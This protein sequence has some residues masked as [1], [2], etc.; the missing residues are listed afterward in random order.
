MSSKWILGARPKTLPAAVVPVSLGTAA[1]F[2]ENVSLLSVALC[3]IVA[4][5]LQVGVNYAN[6]YSDGVRGNDGSERVGPVRL[7]G[8]GLA[9]STQ[10]FRASLI[11]FAT[12]ALSGLWLSLVTTLWLIP[13]GLICIVGAWFYTGGSKPYGYRGLGEVSVFVFF[14]LIATNGSFF[15]QTERLDIEPFLLSCSTGLL[16]CA[17]LTVNNLRDYKNDKKVGKRTLSVLIGE[18]ASRK[19]FGI[20]L[21]L[22]LLMSLAICLWHVWVLLILLT[23]PLLYRSLKFVYRANDVTTWNDALK[24]VSALQISFGL[25]LTVAFALSV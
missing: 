5:S 13:I 21:T 25:L 10:V 2:G 16:S 11:M 14:G 6:D 19:L 24:S 8:G 9:T 17:L 22:S 18:K 12:A 23:I 4:L 3:L 1:A 7:V 20:M 15:V